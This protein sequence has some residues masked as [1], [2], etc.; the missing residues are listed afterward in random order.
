[1]AVEDVVAVGLERGAALQ[2]KGVGA[3]SGFGESVSSSE[4]GGELREIV[5]LLRVVR[6]AHQSG[7]DEG[8]LNIDENAHGWIHCRNLLDS[9]NSFEERAGSPAVLLGNL[10]AHQAEVEEFAEKFGIELLCFVH[11]ADERSDVGAGE[12]ADGGAEEE[13]VGGELGEWGH[14]IWPD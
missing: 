7:D 2:R 11:F 13:F 5:L 3:G 12:V 9:E 1:M 6:P 4:F 14:G 8:V 10:D